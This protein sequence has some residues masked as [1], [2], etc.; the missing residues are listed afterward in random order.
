MSTRPVC[1]AGGKR[2]RTVAGGE[3]VHVE[4]PLHEGERRLLG[5]AKRLLL[6]HR[7]IHLKHVEFSVQGEPGGESLGAVYIGEG[8]SLPYYLRLYRASGLGSGARYGS[9]LRMPRRVAEVR[10][11]LP[12]V[13]VE[14]NEW[15]SSLL[16]P[17]GLH[18]VP[19][20]RQVTDLEGERYR[21]RRH[22]IERNFGWAVRRHD[23][24]FEISR[25][26]DDLE[27]FH[28][29]YHVPHVSR[30]HGSLA[31][32]R[33]L[34]QLE[35][36]MR[37]GFLLRVFQEGSWVSGL[38]VSLADRRRANP[39]AAGLHPS[40]LAGWQ[41]GA[42]SAAYYFLFRWAEEE[43]IRLVDF[44]G[45]RPHLGDGVFQHKVLWGAE[46]TLDSWHHNRVAF[47]L[48][49][50]ARFPASIAQQLVWNDGRF[51]PIVD[52]LVR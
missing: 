10:R 47:Y 27:A 50:A 33:S 18:T 9:V 8:L 16:P 7:S 30:R 51:V 12:I 14:I 22:G 26:R 40:R 43:G 17:G 29:E 25:A 32:V 49:S 4:E 42:L 52:C 21:H 36:A 37:T 31:S 2:H 11:N 35:R 44:G 45:S 28:R 13:I 39:V 3:R 24:Q 19:W 15:L 6:L 20:V 1:W 48:D 5:T 23:F 46:P 34:R 41:D 38:V